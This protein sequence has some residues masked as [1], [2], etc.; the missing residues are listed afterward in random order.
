MTESSPMVALIAGFAVSL[1][2]FAAMASFL[3]LDSLSSAS[4]HHSCI[5]HRWTNAPEN[6]L[7][8]VRPPIAARPDYIET[9]VEF[10]RGTPL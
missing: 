4:R 9:D 5:P 1:L 7:A 6:T 2:V 8:V 3:A 10:S